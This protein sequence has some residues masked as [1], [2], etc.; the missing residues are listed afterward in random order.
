MAATYF[1]YSWVFNEP[2]KSARKFLYGAIKNIPGSITGCHRLHLR[3]HL[4]YQ[5]FWQNI[6]GFN[7][8]SKLGDCSIAPGRKL[9]HPVKP[10]IIIFFRFKG[11]NSLA[12]TQLAHCNRQSPELLKWNIITKPF[13]QDLLCPDP[14]ASNCIF[15]SLSKIL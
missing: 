8:F 13:R 5:C 9:L 2:G 7:P 3:D 10:V 15:I 12:R 4:Y 11:L 14:N 1:S 6:T